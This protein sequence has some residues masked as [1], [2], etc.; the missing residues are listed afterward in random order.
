MIYIQLNEE[1][2]KQKQRNIKLYDVAVVV[3]EREIQNID[4]AK[5]NEDDKMYAFSAIEI[6]EKILEKYPKEEVLF[7][8]TDT[9]CVA[10]LEDK[11]ENKFFE[12]IKVVGVSL[13]L[14]MGSATTLIAFQ[15]ESNMKEMVYEFSRIF[16]VT[17][18]ASK[19]AFAFPYSIGITLGII[20]FF[21]HIGTKKLTHDPTPVELEM[22]EYNNKIQ[23]NVTQK[24]LY[25][26]EDKGNDNGE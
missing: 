14:F 19:L 7:I 4:L 3:C 24:I 12:I 21:N 13:I 9:V 20:I 2:V 17:E 1:I 5:A 6:L 15:I 22:N 23:E 8:G 11:K 26:K 25:S 18:N 10:F 16:G